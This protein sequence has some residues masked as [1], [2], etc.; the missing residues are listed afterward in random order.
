MNLWN[1]LFGDSEPTV[2]TVSGGSHTENPISTHSTITINTK[3][4]N[5]D[6]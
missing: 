5:Y 1:I 2:D 3:D 6:E 4:D